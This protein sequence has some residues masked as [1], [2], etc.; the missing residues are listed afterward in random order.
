VVKRVTGAALRHPSD[1]FGAGEEGLLRYDE[2][3]PLSELS[4]GSS[5]AWLIIEAG[6]A[7]PLA[8]DLGGPDGHPDGIPDTS[9]NNGDGRV[10]ASDVTSEHETFGPLANP[11][12]PPEG[13]PQFHFSQ[14][15]TGGYPMAFTNPFVLDMNGNGRF[16]P[17]RAAGAR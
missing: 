11:P 16:D 10:D 5:D 15:V 3:T 13:H 4:I 7:L 6:S 8:A 14:V 2:G 1:A 17:P 12:A 9:D